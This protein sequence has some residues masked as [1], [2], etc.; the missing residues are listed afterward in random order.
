M[1]L[2]EGE[3]VNK[4]AEKGKTSF[5]K[6]FTLKKILFAKNS[7]SLCKNKRGCFKGDMGGAKRIML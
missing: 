4:T 6:S 3:L 2:K 5:Q 7:K 1:N